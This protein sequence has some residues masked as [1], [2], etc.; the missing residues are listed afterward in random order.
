MRRQARFRRRTSGKL[1][2]LKKTVRANVSGVPIIDLTRSLRP[3]SFPPY[4]RD[5]ACP[6]APD[7]QD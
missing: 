4:K 3:R 1:K 5:A 7:R 6:R 2:R